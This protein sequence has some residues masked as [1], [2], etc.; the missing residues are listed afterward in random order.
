MNELILMEDGWQSFSANIKK[1]SI[2]TKLFKEK[3][4]FYMK[5]ERFEIHNVDIIEE[6]INYYTYEEWKEKLQGCI[7]MDDNIIMHSKKKV[8]YDFLRAYVKQFIVEVY[9]EVEQGNIVRF[10]KFMELYISSHSYFKKNLEFFSRTLRV[11]LL[12]S[13]K[14]KIKIRYKGVLSKKINRKYFYSMLMYHKDN[15]NA[16]HFYNTGDS[17][18]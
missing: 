2:T 10:G 7:P 12:N 8:M 13:F 16:K 15:N 4:I 14:K 17:I 3:E 11:R 5:N 1:R 18:S 9:N 6:V